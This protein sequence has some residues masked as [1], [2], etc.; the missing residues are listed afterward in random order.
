MPSNTARI[1]KNTL[2]LY[3]RQ[4]LIMLVSLY[5]VRIVL[6]SLGIEDFGIYD[7]VFGFVIIFSFFNGAMTNATQRFLNFHMGE[8]DFEQ[9]RNVFNFSFK[10]HL[11]IT[12]LFIVL[13]ETAGILLFNSLLNIPSERQ[14]TAFIVYQFTI[15]SISINILQ[16]PYRALIIAYEKMS[17]FAVIGIFEALLK[18]LTAILL[19]FILYDKLIIYSFFIFI[20]SLI[21]FLSQFIYC[22]LK[23]ETSHFRNFKDKLLFQKMIKFSFWNIFLDFAD[24]CRLHGTNILINIFYGVTVNAA[25]GIASKINTAV[26]T[27]VVNFQTA[28][29]PQ[30]IKSYAAK[31]YNYFIRLIFQTSKMSFFLLFLFV[32]PL[33]LNADFVLKIW[34]NNV[35]EYCVILTK[36]MLIISLETSFNGPLL[37]SILATGDIKKHQ[38]IYSCF[39]FANL[40]VSLIF[41]WLGYSPMYV[42]YVKFALTFLSLI[43]RIIFLNKKI[44]LPVLG[45]LREVIFPIIIVVSIS[46]L[47]VIFSQSLFIDW[48][49]LLITCII[50]T[51]IITVLVYFVG[52]NNQERISLHNWILNKIK[53]PEQIS[54]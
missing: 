45:Y 31:D 43:W 34:L 42:L 49:K 7:V 8:N 1:A 4:V 35:P 53:K 51:V 25:M 40:P 46:T 22:N 50:S 38:L 52:I 32:L 24:V 12:L 18:L 9:T 44:N 41:L 36:L 15:A 33:Y 54:C 26:Y 39:L 13:T 47:V 27:F 16:T 14:D 3:F 21:I 5:A 11:L 37:D 17:I 48:T 10:I 6:N 19:I 20:V 30:I 29:R 28:Y 23:F 2:L